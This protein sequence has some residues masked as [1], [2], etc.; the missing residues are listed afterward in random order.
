[1]EVA[2]KITTGNKKNKSCN[3]QSWTFHILGYDHSMVMKGSRALTPCFQKGGIWTS[4]YKGSMSHILLTQAK[5][6]C[7]NLLKIAQDFSPGQEKYESYMYLSD[8]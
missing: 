1:M 6:N 8:E 4:F 5:T 2:K 7:S 3:S